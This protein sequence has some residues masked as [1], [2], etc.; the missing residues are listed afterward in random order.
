MAMTNE[1]HEALLETIRDAGANWMPGHNDMTD[2]EPEERRLRLGYVPGPGEPTLEEREAQGAE[3]QAMAGVLAPPLPAKVDWRS[4]NG[5]NFVTSIKDQQSC[6]SC[7]A[8]GT[9]AT[10]ESRARILKGIPMN[11]PNGGSLPDLSEAHLFYCGNT[12]ADP[13]GQG[14]WPAQALAFATGTG[15][16]PEAC[17]PYTPG[18][19]PCAPC[20]GWQG[21]VTKVATSRTLT[22]IQSMKQWLSTNG[23]LIACFSVYDDF[24]AYTSGVYVHTTGR[25]EGGHCVSCVGYDDAKQAWVCKNSW[26]TRWGAGGFFWIKYGQVGI[27]AAMW[28]VDTFTTIYVPQTPPHIRIVNH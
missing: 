8:F 4:D 14:W 10:M 11:A 20:N 23:P 17:F 16:V 22:T 27:D 12:I 7:V 3:L 28:A 21:Q 13:C 19:Q 18:N 1:E 24:Y 2:L 9:A 26:G 15:V 6:G 5:Q 25:L